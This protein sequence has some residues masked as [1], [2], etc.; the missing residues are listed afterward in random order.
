MS[1][2]TATP[3]TADR[4]SFEHNGETLT[5]EKSFSTVRSP[6]WLRANRRRDEVDLIFTILEELGGDDVIEAVDTMTTEEFNAAFG[7]RLMKEL[8]AAFQ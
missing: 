3:D 8:G 5:F 7:K 2:T 1:D 6:K 4:Y